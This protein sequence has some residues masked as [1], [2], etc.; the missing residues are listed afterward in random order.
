M[1][2]QAK[3][4]TQEVGNENLVN[5][6]FTYHLHGDNESA[7]RI[8]SEF[9]QRWPEHIE[10]NYN[11]AVCYRLTGQTQEA[12]K[13]FHKARSLIE[14]ARDDQG[15]LNQRLAMLSQLIDHQLALM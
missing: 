15:D 8:L 4:D 10:A 13:L 3:Q 1:E 12:A 7:I 2:E 14:K 5:E 9:V 11:L 6:A